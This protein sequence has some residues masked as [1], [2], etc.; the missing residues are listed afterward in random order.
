MAQ[1]VQLGDVHTWYDEHGDGEPLM[2]MHGGLVD[3]RFMEP[4]LGPLS[5]RWTS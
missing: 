3:S 1:Y 4:N 2:L 5:E